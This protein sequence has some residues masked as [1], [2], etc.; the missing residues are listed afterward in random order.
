MVGRSSIGE[1]VSRGGIIR[2]GETIQQL[3][4]VEYIAWQNMIQRCTN[5]NFE[6]YADYG[7][8]GI[9]V[10]SDWLGCG[11]F[12]RF[13]KHVGRRPS[14]KHTLDRKNND[15]GYQPGNVRWATR[16]Q[17]NVNTSKNVLITCRGQTKSIA[18]WC[19]LV[20]MA[21]STMCTR[22]HLGW[23]SEDVIFKPIRYKS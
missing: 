16:K 8:R 2:H 5:P 6:Q 11:G 1:N 9:S 4:S 19:Q 17:Q 22:I 20:G 12:E 21:H 15:L 14:T 23:D 13:L 7:G 10:C 18:E 3:R